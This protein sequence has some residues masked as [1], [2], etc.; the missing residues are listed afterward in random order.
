M[1]LQ[2]EGGGLQG[3][4]YIPKSW[5]GWADASP[6]QYIAEGGDS[7]SQ[8]LWAYGRPAGY[9]FNNAD[10]AQDPFFSSPFYRNT[11]NY[12]WT[13]DPTTGAPSVRVKTADKTGTTVKFV[14]DGQGNWVPDYGQQMQAHWDTNHN[15]DFYRGIGTVAG[16][17]I[18]GNLAA[19]SGMLGAGAQG[20]WNAGMT[21]TAA[22]AGTAGAGGAWGVVDPSFTAFNAVPGAAGGAVNPY[23]L[24][25]A[26]LG[27][28]VETYLGPGA[29]AGEMSGSMAGA[30]LPTSGVAGGINWGELATKYG[31]SLAKLAPSAVQAVIG[32]INAGQG[33][34]AVDDILA[35]E[36]GAA[37]EYRA[38]GMDYASGVRDLWSQNQGMFGYKPGNVTTGV[39]STRIDPATGQVTYDLSQPYQ[40]AR[41]Q[42]FKA[43]EG[44]FGQIGSFDP[45]AHATERYNSALGLMAEGD[46]Q[47][48]NQLMN[49][50]YSKG[51]F[52]L[53]LN[54]QAAASAA[55]GG[56]VTPGTGT[57][58][59]NPYVDTF[60][61]ATNRR[62]A[63]L[64]YKS[65]NEGESYLD[66][67]IRRQQGMFGFGA[68]IDK[69]GAGLLD[70]A[71]GWGRDFTSASRDQGLNNML[72]G[73]QALRSERDAV[74]GYISKVL[75]AQNEAQSA[76]VA[77]RQQQG[78]IWG[79]V[80]KN[81]DWG[82]IIK[83]IWG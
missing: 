11:N 65:L 32:A 31:P 79:D 43:S 7:G 74:Q 72:Y 25:A 68:G 78:S 45:R 64:S 24:T 21:G 55:P 27:A 5:I 39:G 15:D 56:G 70:T 22:G 37:G 13:F 73:D 46:A 38:A 50:L 48:N 36:I 61:N 14:E 30:A 19:A 8:R 49:D 17:A 20:A 28:P 77:A 3:L 10:V 47:R 41:D 54:Q 76:D 71:Q 29:I 58:G 18:G 12:E 35:R 40:T 69:M 67:M 1:A 26:E 2:I 66:N 59:V 34:K 53:T 44:M 16:A 62:N 51:G 80:A 9:G 23:A 81:V 83:G 6:D 4:P 63:E 57:V 52:G 60:L 82:S 75:G 33:E 42:A